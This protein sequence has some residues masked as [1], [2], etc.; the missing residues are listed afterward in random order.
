MRKLIVNLRIMIEIRFDF[1]EK[2]LILIN[3]KLR[4]LYTFYV[5]I[6]KILLK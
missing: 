1:H 5:K 3:F 2:N 4:I 6:I